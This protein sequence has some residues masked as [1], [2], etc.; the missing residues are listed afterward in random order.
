M[1]TTEL[2]EHELPAVEALLG[3]TL[4]LMTGYAQALQADTCPAQRL[5]MG[6]KVAHNLGLLAEHGGVSAAMATVVQRLAQRWQQM[7][8]CSCEAWPGLASPAGAAVH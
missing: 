5:A 2:E 6:A 1:P 4:A 3:A 8:R 7:T